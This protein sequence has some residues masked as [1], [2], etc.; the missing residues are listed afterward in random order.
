MH[1]DIEAFFI[2]GETATAVT[3]GG[4][5]HLAIFDTASELVVGD[6]LV[7]EPTL[8]L[9]TYRAA[10]MAQGTAAIVNAITY[11]TRQVLVEPP[12]GELTRL[13][14]TKV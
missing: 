5:P 8:L 11:R 7:R 3:I 12:D 10:G 14:L 13:V 9:P 4:Q 6:V 2:E 1:E